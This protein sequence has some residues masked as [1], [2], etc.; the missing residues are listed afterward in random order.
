MPDS[1]KPADDSPI[2]DEEGAPEEELSD[3]DIYHLNSD[4]ESSSDSSLG[5]FYDPS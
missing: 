4:N 1:Q 5:K 2:S 3:E